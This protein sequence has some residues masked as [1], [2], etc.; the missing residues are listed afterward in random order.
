MVFGLPLLET[1]RLSPPEI[2]ICSPVSPAPPSRH[3]SAS[4]GRPAIVHSVT[5]QMEDMATHFS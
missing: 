5:F 4:Q 2:F 3:L 1:Q